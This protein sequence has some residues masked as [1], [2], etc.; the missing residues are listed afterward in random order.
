MK[1]TA[2][3]AALSTILL[4]SSHPQIFA[5]DIS[6]TPTGQIKFYQSQ[7]LGDETEDHETETKKTEQSEQN[8]QAEEKNREEDKKRAE[9][10]QK[11][12][13]QNRENKKQEAEKS[14]KLVAPSSS[15]ELKIS[16]VKNKIKI[17]LKKKKT[18]LTEPTTSFERSETMETERLRLNM[19]AEIKDSEKEDEVEEE[20]EDD[21]IENEVEKDEAE[22]DR[23]YQQK[24]SEERKQRTQEMIEIKNKLREQQQSLEI[25]SRDVS[26]HLGGGAEF[27]VD[28]VTNE[29]SI[30]TPSGNT[31]VLHHLPDQA[32]EQMSAHGVDTNVDQ[33]QITTGDNG[34]VKFA[35]KAMKQKKL[36]GLFKREV[37]TEVEL[38]DNTGEVVE[39]E[40]QPDTLFASLLNRLSI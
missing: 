26:A 14:F 3:I 24:L 23:E 15:Q 33:L 31:H 18:G 25:K 7:V 19:P 37:E 17:E 27:V 22:I 1:K 35:A 16:P 36:L 34:Q 21:E 10:T 8:K 38:D 28:P 5:L 39:T 40:I 11:I 30:I 12:Q 6:I 32:L 29:L 9:E 4:I 2:L 20:V 13:E